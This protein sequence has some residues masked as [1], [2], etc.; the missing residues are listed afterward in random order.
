MSLLNLRV[1][2]G[3]R[4][5]HAHRWGLALKNTHTHDVPGGVIRASAVA[6]VFYPADPGELART[7]AGM[8]RGEDVVGSPGVRGIIA[9]HAGYLYSGPTAA[10]AYGR[11]ARGAYDIVVVVAPSHREYFEGVS[12][13]DGE[14][15]RTP[16]GT[17]P[18]ERDLRDALIQA[19]PFVRSSAEGHGE[20]HAVEVHL[21]FLQSALGPFSFLPVVIGHQTPET[22]FAL[23]EAL[24]G[25][26][27]HRR[28][29]IVAS[30]DLSHFHSDSEAREIDAVVIGDVRG[31][32]PRALM[33]HLTEGSAE[34]CGGGPVVAVMTA[35]KSLG[36]TRV[37]VMEYATSGDVT[38]DRRSVVGYL[39][40]VAF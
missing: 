27:R 5:V 10:R 36:A 37:E 9:P 2:S 26:L 16:L 25:L 29:L 34:A 28:A 6:G 19:A 15:Y 33:S 17:V 21:P 7:I 32:D 30:T 31:F 14:A 22:C 1:R 24:G 13:Y 4:V 20:E 40:A 38:G 39:S 23:G 3:E 12:V 8:I 11:L 18:V 35:L